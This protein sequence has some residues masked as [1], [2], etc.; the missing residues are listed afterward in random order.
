MRCSSEAL[1]RAL[2]LAV[3]NQDETA[4][5]GS[6]RHFIELVRKK[7]GAG[8]LNKVLSSLPA[9]AKAAEA[10][11]EVVVESARPLSPALVDEALRRLKIDPAKAAVE[12]RVSPEL[13]GGIRIRYRDRLL[14]TS[15]K[16]KIQRLA[17]LAAERSSFE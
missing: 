8:V 13:I 10:V 9:A 4:A 12:E 1:A 15:I 14:D 16:G 5:L 3:R 7:Y 2:Y 11:E 6:I 17:G